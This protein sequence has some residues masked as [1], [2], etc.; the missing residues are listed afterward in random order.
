LENIEQILREEE[1][2]GLPSITSLTSKPS[3]PDTLESKSS[4]GFDLALKKRVDSKLKAQNKLGVIYD[5]LSCHYILN[6][7]IVVI[8]DTEYTSVKNSAL[9]NK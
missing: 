9:A 1:Q 6:R 4:Y 3:N 8:V 5:M 2:E 7:S